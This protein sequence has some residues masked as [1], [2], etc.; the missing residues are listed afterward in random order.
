MK[1]SSKFTAGSGYQCLGNT[2]GHPAKLSTHHEASNL[3]KFMSMKH[4]KSGSA[5]GSGLTSL[6]INQDSHRNMHKQKEQY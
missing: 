4:G 5:A 3:S 1:S 6:T 2:A